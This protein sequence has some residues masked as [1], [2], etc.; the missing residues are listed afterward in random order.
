MIKTKETQNFKLLRQV[1][2]FIL[3]SNFLSNRSFIS[4]E[5]KS[6]RKLLHDYIKSKF[7]NYLSNTVQQSKDQLIEVY[8]KFYAVPLNF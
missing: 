6:E 8:H 1:T 7:A 3:S 2:N 4:Q 5:D